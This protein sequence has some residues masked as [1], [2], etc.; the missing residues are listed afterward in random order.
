MFLLFA[1]SNEIV[2]AIEV[3]SAYRTNCR[4]AKQHKFSEQQASALF[5]LA[6]NL[7]EN[8]IGITITHSLIR[9][10]V[11]LMFDIRWVQPR[12]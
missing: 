9:I 10:Q 4:L 12:G 8:A 1:V 11:V 6:F 5:H 7:L 2:P 3:I